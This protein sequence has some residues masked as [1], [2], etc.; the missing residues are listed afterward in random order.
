ML[1]LLSRAGV[2]DFDAL[3]DLVAAGRFRAA[4][5]V[6]PV[7]PAPADSRAREIE[8]LLLSPHRAGS[9]PATFA[10]IGEMVVDDVGLILAGPAAA[11]AAAG[12]HARPWA[13]GESAGPHLRAGD[14]AVTSLAAAL[15]GDA[16]AR[17]L[18]V[19]VDDVG[20]CHGANTAFL[21]LAR[22][23]A[24]HLRLGDGAL[25]VVPRDRGRRGR[26]TGRSTSACT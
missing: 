8:G 17:L 23:G 15:A 1:L 20:M 19:H 11:A 24:G 6:F 21:E 4:T 9:S 26:R 2:V 12:A 18:A 3:L 13:A 16:R 10:T 25:P 5:D 7:E 22:A 14:E